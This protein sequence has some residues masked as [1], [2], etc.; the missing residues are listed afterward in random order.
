MHGS[1]YN[2]REISEI[3]RKASREEDVNSSAIL[4]VLFDFMERATLFVLS[5]KRDNMRLE[6]E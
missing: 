2:R 1:N 5:R 6:A 3:S 4:S